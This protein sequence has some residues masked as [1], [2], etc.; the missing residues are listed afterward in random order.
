MEKIIDKSNDVSEILK[1][2]QSINEV[3]IN[4]T[5]TVNTTNANPALYF[6]RFLNYSHPLC[7]HYH[8]LLMCTLILQR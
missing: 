2:N 8:T 6:L 1:A 7:I 5:T 4:T 3:I